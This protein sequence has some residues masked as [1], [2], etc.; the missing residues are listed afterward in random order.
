MPLDMLPV[1]LIYWPPLI[2]ATWVLPGA[3]AAIGSAIA[4][5]QSTPHFRHQDTIAIAGYWWL[6][7]AIGIYSG[8]AL[9]VLLVSIALLFP[10]HLSRLLDYLA[11]A[12]SL[13]AAGG[14]GAWIA[15]KLSLAHVRPPAAE[16]SDAA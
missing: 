11:P 3:V 4:V 13:A 2:L 16:Q 14:L 10:P 8:T 15:G 6:G 7:M 9:Y 1:L 5:A 12:L